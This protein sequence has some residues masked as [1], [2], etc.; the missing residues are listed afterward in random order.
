MHKPLETPFKKVHNIIMEKI[1]R[2]ILQ[3]NEEIEYGTVASIKPYVLKR[4]IAPL[5]IL[6]IATTILTILAIVF[7]YHY[8]G[9]GWHGSD[10]SW[11][12]YEGIPFYVPIIVFTV[13]GLI[14]LFVFISSF[15]AAKNYA[16]AVTDKRILIKKGAFR[17][18]FEALPFTDVISSSII[19]RYRS[20]FDDKDENDC[21]LY[22]SIP[23]RVSISLYTPSLMDGFDFSRRLEKSVQDRIT[24]GEKVS[25]F[26]IL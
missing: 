26:V 10:Y 12:D 8:V 4:M 1:F 9:K 18:D 24:V 2:H 3:E 20:I 16:I 14:N 25:I 17:P 7:P 13:L 22:I 5:I 6:I 11:N 15:K 19:K 21:S 23:A